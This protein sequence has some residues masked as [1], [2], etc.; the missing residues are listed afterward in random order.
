MSKN[1][2][3]KKTQNNAQI[4][5]FN[6]RGFPRDFDMSAKIRYELESKTNLK[7]ESLIHLIMSYGFKEYDPK[8]KKDRYQ[9]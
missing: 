5:L 2:H 6:P 9:S 8:T 1:H 4:Y 7:G 3:L